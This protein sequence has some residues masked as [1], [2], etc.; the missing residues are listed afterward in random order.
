MERIR[1]RRS[2]VRTQLGITQEEKKIKRELGIT[3]LLRPF[4]W[5]LMGVPFA[6]GWFLK[7]AATPPAQPGASA[8]APWAPAPTSPST[9]EREP[10]RFR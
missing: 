2:S 4:R 6:L 10:E 7:S 5:F 9:A 1:Y 3:A 8:P